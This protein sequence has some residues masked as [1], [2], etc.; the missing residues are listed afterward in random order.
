MSAAF[1]GFRIEYLIDH[2]NPMNPNPARLAFV[3][4]LECGAEIL[5]EA[6]YMAKTCTE[7]TCKKCGNHSIKPN[8]VRRPET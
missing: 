5:R 1:P 3:T 6:H 2:D 8:E 4:C 7:I